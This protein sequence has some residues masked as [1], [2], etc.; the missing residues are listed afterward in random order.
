MGISHFF[1]N[2]SCKDL[3]ERYKHKNQ[4]RGKKLRPYYAFI[5]HGCNVSRIDD[6]TNC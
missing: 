4:G 6:S 1:T 2:I 5:T 3:R